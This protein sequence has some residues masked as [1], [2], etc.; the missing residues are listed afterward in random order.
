MDQLSRSDDLLAHLERAHFDLAVVDEAHRMSARYYSGELK[1]TK[2]YELG[3]LLGNGS[4]HLLLMTA[5]PHAGKEEDF[6]LLL[7]L[8]DGDRFVGRHRK[9]HDATDVYGLMLRRVKEELLTFEGRP[10]FP[11]RFA[12]TVPYSS[13]TGEPSCTSRSRPTSATR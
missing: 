10:L 2:R 4:E 7:A 6:Q 3:E 5:T 1:R 13:R 12:A 8:L 9:A 11:E